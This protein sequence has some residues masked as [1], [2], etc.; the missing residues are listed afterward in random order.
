M[1]TSFMG[2]NCLDLI[3]YAIFTGSFHD[4]KNRIKRLSEQYPSSLL[5]IT[6]ELSI[7]NAFSFIIM[8]KNKA[9]I[10]GGIVH[11]EH[12]NSWLVHT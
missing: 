2:N 5:I 8:L 3:E 7:K 12:S 1:N 11:D 9:E 4:L 6:K 10:Q